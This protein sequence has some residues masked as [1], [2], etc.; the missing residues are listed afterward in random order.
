MKKLFGFLL[1]VAAF[2][3]CTISASAGH[4]DEDITIDPSFNP[5]FD[6]IVDDSAAEREKTIAELYEL[7]NSQYAELNR[8]I[9]ELEEKFKG[10]VFI[11]YTDNESEN[12]QDF[13]EGYLEEQ[14]MFNENAIIFVLNV[15]KR[16]FYVA[17]SG[18]MIDFITDI[19]LSQL[20]DE[21]EGYLKARVVDDMSVY[22][23][24]LR[25]NVAKLFLEKINEFV[26]AGI[27]SRN[28][29]MDADTGEIIYLKSIT[30]IEAGVAALIAALFGIACYRG[31]IK[32]YKPKKFKEYVYPIYKNAKLTLLEEENELTESKKFYVHPRHYRRNHFDD[33]YHGGG[34]GGSSGGGFS[35]GSSSGG[36]SSA[37]NGSSG[38][39]FG[40]GGRSF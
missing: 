39:S 6:D 34:S 7:T 23:N 24:S 40:G 3:V 2:F 11:V 27:P 15:S 14:G 30:P 1:V 4:V 10:Q 33:H 21:L 36:G 32:K 18:N 25:V 9:E 31:I 19:R 20:L 35:G 5:M 26:D 29:R 16:E 8:G 17:T 38:G 22:G 28:Y 12:I 13:A 37:G